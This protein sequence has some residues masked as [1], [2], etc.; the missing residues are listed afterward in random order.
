MVRKL[1]TKEIEE[2]IPALYSTDDTEADEKTVVVK[3]FSPYSGWTWYVFEGSRQE[4]G[5]F[6]F[7]GAVHGFVNEL[8]YFSLRELESAKKGS[9]SLIERDTSFTPTTYGEIKKKGR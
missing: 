7:F 4:D 1:L 6:L 2:K 5:D 9:L 8:G 3:F